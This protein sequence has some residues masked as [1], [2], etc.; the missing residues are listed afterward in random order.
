[1][2]LLNTFTNKDILV[3]LLYAIPYL[4]IIGGIIYN[5]VKY[6]KK[7]GV[8]YNSIMTITKSLA[9]NEQFKKIV[10]EAIK[11]IAETTS[12]E[13]AEELD[14]AITSLKKYLSTYLYSNMQLTDSIIETDPEDDMIADILKENNINIDNIENIINSILNAMGY[15]D[16]TIKYLIVEA[17]KEKNKK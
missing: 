6:I 3:L 12:I 16:T 17:V 14:N 10:D 1:M 7:H 5:I 2:I 15:N 8:N 13:Y 4:I 11:L 9:N